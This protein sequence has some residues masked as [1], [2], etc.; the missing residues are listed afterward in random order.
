MYVKTKKVGLR[1]LE[2]L[3]QLSKSCMLPLHHKPSFSKI[4]SFLGKS[5]KT[6]GSMH[7]K[8]IERCKFLCSLGLTA[9]IYFYMKERLR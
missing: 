3:R 8:E 5:G 2:L 9:N 6:S 1:R 4:I 7:Q